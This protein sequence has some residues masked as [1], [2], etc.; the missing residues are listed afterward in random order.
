MEG[1]VDLGTAK[2]A[3]QPRSIQLAEAD[4]DLL[5]VADA[6]PYTGP[7]IPKC[8][9]SRS[10]A[11]WEPRRAFAYASQVWSAASNARAIA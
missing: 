6:H 3:Q 11:T 8:A 1:H 7:T 5:S 4:E 9:V 10:D 2:G